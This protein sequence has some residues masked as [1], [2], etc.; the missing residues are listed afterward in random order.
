MNYLEQY[1]KNLCEQL[2]DQITSLLRLVEKSDKVED[3]D[4][5]DKSGNIKNTDPNK[6]RPSENYVQSMVGIAPAKIYSD[7]KKYSNDKPDEVSENTINYLDNLLEKRF[8]ISKFKKSKKGDKKDDKKSDKKVGK[9]YDGDGKVESA[10]DEYFGSKD[11]AIKKAIVDK[12]KKK[13]IKEGREISGGQFTYGGFPRI[14][15]EARYTIPAKATDKDMEDP[16][17]VGMLEFEKL[18]KSGSHPMMG[19]Q[20]QN[21]TRGIS[22]EIRKQAL[23][24]IDAL[25]KHAPGKVEGYSNKHPVY[26]EGMA[27]Y[28]FFKKNFPA[29]G[30]EDEIGED[31][32]IEGHSP[33]E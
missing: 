14:L 25:K 23:E 24:H 20:T 11:K 26:K 10:K 22:P 28:Q 27:A 16:S 3:G 15:T 30:V 29:F 2:Q 21:G 19:N 4:Y 6:A 31:Y 18:M 1:Y 9:D 32:G 33:S 17:Q 12:K 7:M 13:N 8:D 5:S